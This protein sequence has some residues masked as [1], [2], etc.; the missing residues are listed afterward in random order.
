[1]TK[2]RKSPSL[3]D[4]EYFKV[5]S[6]AAIHFEMLSDE[7]RTGTYL[8]AMET[9]ADFIRGRVVLDVG[10]GNGILSLFAARI[11]ASKVYA[12]EAS[13]IVEDL[14][15]VVKA[16]GYEEV[17][18]VVHGKMEEVVL[19]EKVDVILSEWMGY[20][21]VYESMLES[22]LFA[23]DR[24]LLP[25]GLLFPSKAEIYIAAW[26]S[27]D[28][29][30]QT[31]SFWQNVYGFDFTAYR[32][33]ALKSASSE[34]L[35]ES[36]DVSEIVSKSQCVL[37]IDLSNCEKIQVHQWDHAFSFEMYTGK[38]LT[39][40]CGWFDV[41]FPGGAR[42]STGPSEDETHWAQ[43]CFVFDEVVQVEQ[44]DVVCGIVK[45]KRNSIHLRSVD[46]EFLVELRPGLH[47]KGNA[48]VFRQK[49]MIK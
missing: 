7:R 40:M 22:V 44:G 14:R 35:V 9:N 12:V 17:V 48:K 23:R 33:M 1:M 37:E 31:H 10:A 42:L 39:G 6:D 43:T 46:V 5:Y 19:P 3:D 30:E 18:N 25:G 34:A 16:N 32:G 4:E 15:K 13:G 2:R 49:F 38:P 29:H 41:T 36:V 27:D 47:S 24:W 28:L 21:L 45:G 26:S 8:R 11:G 20:F